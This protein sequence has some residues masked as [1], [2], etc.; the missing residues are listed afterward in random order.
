MSHKS[1]IYGMINSEKLATVKR[2]VFS[3]DIPVTLVFF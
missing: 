1:V 2:S 3:F